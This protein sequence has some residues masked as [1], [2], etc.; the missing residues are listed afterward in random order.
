LGLMAEGLIDGLRVDHPDGL[1]DPRGYLER[2][3]KATGGAWVA[4]E[5]IL[6]GDEE[7]P[8][9][10]RCAG[11]T[12]YDALGRAGGV[13]L[14]PAGA[15]PLAAGYVRFTGGTP[16]FAAVAETAKREVARGS[17]GAEVRRLV[18]LLPRRADP[19][20]RGLAARDLRTVVAELLTAIPVYRAYVVPGEP[21]PATSVNIMA[22]AP[23]PARPPPPPPPRPA[24]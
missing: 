21:A 3:A 2:L 22:G 4:C 23:A 11:T 9:D 19:A 10:W 1:A 12:G 24:P 15:S 5:K 13:F 20:L 8:A 18:G 14:D 7:L 6:T 17:L 16:R